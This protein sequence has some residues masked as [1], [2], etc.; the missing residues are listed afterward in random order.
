MTPEEAGRELAALKVRA[1]FLSKMDLY[2]KLHEKSDE[3]DTMTEGEISIM[4]LL[5]QDPDI[6]EFMDRKREVKP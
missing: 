6:Q 1:L 5:S 3:P 4:Y 2:R